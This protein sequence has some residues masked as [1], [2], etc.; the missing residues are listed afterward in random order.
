M[1][2]VTAGGWALGVAIRHSLPLDGFARFIAE[3]TLWLIVVGLAASPLAS[4]RLRGR[5]SDMIPG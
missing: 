5:L 4:A 2:I 3:C 1:V